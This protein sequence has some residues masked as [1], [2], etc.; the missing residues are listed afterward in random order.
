M[1]A[2]LRDGD[3]I[4]FFGDVQHDIGWLNERIGPRAIEDSWNWHKRAL[5]N[6]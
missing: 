5:H 2:T 3:A 1:I 6:I 4:I